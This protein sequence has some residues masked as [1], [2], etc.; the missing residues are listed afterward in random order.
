MYYS[1]KY[2]KIWR[3]FCKV[4]G[5]RPRK[6]VPVYGEP[7]LPH[8][9]PFVQVTSIHITKTQEKWVQLI[10]PIF[11][12]DLKL[13]FLETNNIKVPIYELTMAINNSDVY[14]VFRKYGNI[15]YFNRTNITMADYAQHFIDWI[16][17]K[18]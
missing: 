10:A 6:I 11:A 1:I 3:R 14:S 13:Y 7:F 4:E 18:K 8:L 17:G 16:E 5:L 9:Y 12:E 15:T 2:E